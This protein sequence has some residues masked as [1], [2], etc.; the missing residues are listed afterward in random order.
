MNDSYQVQVSNDL[1]EGWTPMRPPQ[2]HGSGA[3]LSGDYWH[4]TMREARAHAEK[5]NEALTW[6]KVRIVR[7]DMS[8]RISVAL[9]AV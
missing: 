1:D 5:L 9:P 3:G 7:K 2:N 8:G 6:R 4:M